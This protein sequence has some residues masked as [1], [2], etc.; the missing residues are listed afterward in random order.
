MP[1]KVEHMQRND[2]VARIGPLFVSC[3][4]GALLV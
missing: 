3:T 4:P 1:A 2:W